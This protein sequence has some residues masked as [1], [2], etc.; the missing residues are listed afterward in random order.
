MGLWALL[1]AP[2]VSALHN[3]ITVQKLSI[4]TPPE[5][6]C[7]GVPVIYLAR[8]IACPEPLRRLW[9]DQ[10]RAAQEYKP[11]L[12]LPSQLKLIACPADMSLWYSADATPAAQLST[13]HTC[14]M[15]LLGALV[16]EGALAT[17]ARVGVLACA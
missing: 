10:L 3:T 11:D 14:R 13:L 8:C 16:H 6:Y 5:V 15:T 9:Y 17:P 12:W 2:N 4:A 1:V 7:D